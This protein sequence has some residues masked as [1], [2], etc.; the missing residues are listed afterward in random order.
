[1]NK[2]GKGLLVNVYRIIQLAKKK[3]KILMENK[4]K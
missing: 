1:M 3:I 2:T 4:D